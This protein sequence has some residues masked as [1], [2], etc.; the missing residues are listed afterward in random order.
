M[1]ERSTDLNTVKKWLDELL[2]HNKLA[3]ATKI[4]EWVFS[5]GV[6]NPKIQ[7]KAYKAQKISK[8][9]TD[10]RFCFAYDGDEF[11][12]RGRETHFFVIKKYHMQVI[13]SPESL[14][15]YQEYLEKDQKFYFISKDDL[16]NLW[17]KNDLKEIIYHAF[18]QRAQERKLI[19]IKTPFEF[20]KN[21]P[22]SLNEEQTNDTLLKEELLK[23]KH[24]LEEIAKAVFGGRV[25]PKKLFDYFEEQSIIKQRNLPLNWRELIMEL[26]KV[27]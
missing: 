5:I 14:R 12:E 17:K 26:V 3:L 2:P 6:S 1:A 20:L 16:E 25:D 9:I 8:P 24:E 27:S 18:Y 19:V 21:E 11:L 13:V 15:K 10:I 4:A 22:L 7:I 23:I